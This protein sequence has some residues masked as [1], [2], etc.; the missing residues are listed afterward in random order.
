MSGNPIKLALGQL[1]LTQVR[2]VTPVRP[3]A[4]GAIASQVYEQV[5]RDFGILAPPV[6]LHSP[7]PMVM[8]AVWVMLRESLVVRGQVERAAK[9]AVA[10]AV[11]E[12]N[13]CPFCETIHSGTLASLSGARGPLGLA[14]GGAAPAADPRLSTAAAWAAACATESGALRSGP[15]YPAEQLPELIGTAVL[16]HYLNRMV[17]VFL[18]EVPLPPRVPRIALRPVM[19]VLGGM[20]RKAGAG[21]LP[22]GASL[23]LLPAAPLPADLGWAAA[24]PVLADGFARAAAAIDAAADRT[25]AEP[26]RELVLAELAGWGGESRGLSRS[27]VTDA[28]DRLPAPH[29][30]AG[31]L[32]LLTAFASYQVDDQIVEAC[33]RGQR[34]DEEL[35]TLTA[36]ASLAAARRIGQWIPVR[37]A[38]G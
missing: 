37:P 21:P 18:V 29:Q 25:V 30:A 19:G 26:V 34:G 22:P 14:D 4:A 2:H 3:R 28:A 7:A 16:L 15:V 23:G 35:I 6:A 9:E 10:T 17:N 31:R 13:T 36:W 33:R 1:G 20:I 38:H 32:A 12:A 5:E 8:A 27:L 24:N 11:S